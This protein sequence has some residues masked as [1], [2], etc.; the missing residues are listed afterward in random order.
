MHIF[1]CGWARIAAAQ[2][3]Q[4]R[5]IYGA[6]DSTVPVRNGG[7]PDA[8]D[9]EHS[10]QAGTLIEGAAGAAGAAGALPEDP[11]AEV[12]DGEVER[13]VLV[14]LGSAVEALAV[15]VVGPVDTGPVDTGP[16][17]TAPA[18]IV[19]TGDAADVDGT[20]AAGLAVVLDAVGLGVP[21]PRLT[22][23]LTVTVPGVALV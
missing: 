21:M 8:P 3:P 7:M 16:V 20:A 6:Q 1:S 23:P 18:P 14:A 11:P 22:T 9:G 5:P 2:W 15:D 12:G 10:T 4:I 17:D 13:A 19:A